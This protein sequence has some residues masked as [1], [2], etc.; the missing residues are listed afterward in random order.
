MNGAEL[1][2]LAFDSQLAGPPAV[3]GGVVHVS[4]S[5]GR[6]AAIDI[7]G[8]RRWQVGVSD[9]LLTGPV[10]TDGRLYVAGHEL[11]CLAGNTE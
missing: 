9:S 7:N 1:W 6:V 5:D 11:I 4:T 8:D 2:Q 3:A 10:V